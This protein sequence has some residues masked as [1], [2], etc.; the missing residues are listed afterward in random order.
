MTLVLT[1]FSNVLHCFI[2]IRG[3][4]SQLRSDQGGN[5]TGAKKEFLEMMKGMEQE[6]V[7]ELG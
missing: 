3:N 5:F 4:V 1:P 7:K 6:H 2:S